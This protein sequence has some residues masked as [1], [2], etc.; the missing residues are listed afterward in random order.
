MSVFGAAGMAIKG[1]IRIEKWSPGRSPDDGPPDEIV[2][3]EQWV[4]R[5]GIVTDPERIVELE[6]L[7]E[8]QKG[9][10]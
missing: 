8:E 5:G 2:T 3:A 4:E 7:A 10:R 1:N 9:R 6:R